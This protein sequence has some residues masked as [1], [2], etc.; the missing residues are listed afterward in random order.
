[1]KYNK[2]IIITLFMFLL[3]VSSVS[4]SLTDGLIS[5]WKFDENTGTNA[6]D[7]VGSNHGTITGATWTTGKINYGLSFDGTN[8][9]LSVLDSPSFDNNKSLVYGGWFNQ[10]SNKNVRILS[11]QGANNPMWSIAIVSDKVVCY[12]RD[13][14]GN[15]IA[16][17][18]TS[19]ITDNTWNMAYCVADGTTLKLYF[20]GVNEAN[21][22][23]STLS[24]NV[25]PINN[26]D[27]GR[28]YTGEYFN[29]L[30][31]EVAIWINKS[32]SNEQILQI[33]N[34]GAG[35]QY[36]FTTES[37]KFKITTNL[38]DFNVS[39]TPNI[40]S[41][42]VNI[43]NV[44]IADFEIAGTTTKIIK[45]KVGNYY[46]SDL[47]QVPSTCV[48]YAYDETEGITFK[49]VN[50]SVGNYEIY[51]KNE[52]SNWVYV[53]YFTDVSG[54]FDLPLY[55][56][57]VMPINS[58]STS[59]TTYLDL[60]DETLY[61]IT[62]NATNYE[63]QTYTDYNISLNGS[64]STTLIPLTKVNFLAKDLYNNDV[65]TFNITY[66]GTTYN[67]SQTISIPTGAGYYNFTFSKTNWYNYTQE[68]YLESIEQTKTFTNLYQ[69]VFNVTL[70]DISTNATINEN[71]VFN[72]TY[73]GTTYT[74]NIT[75]GTTSFNTIYGVHSNLFM[76]TDTYYNHYESDV[77]VT[78]ATNNQIYYLYK[79]RS[80]WF[81]LKDF[82]N[83]DSLENFSVSVYSETNVYNGSTTNNVIKLDNFT[84]GVYSV[85]YFKTGY[86]NVNY[87]ITIQNKSHQTLTGYMVNESLDNYASTIFNIENVVTSGSIYGATI[88]MYKLINNEWV[89][90]AS[91]FSDITGR[92]SFGFLTQLE[93]KFV[94]TKTGYEQREFLLMPLYTTYTIKMTPTQTPYTQYNTNWA[95]YLS[96]NGIFY[97][98]QLNVFDVSLSSGKGTFE[99]YDITITNYDGTNQ[100]ITCT[101]AYG[102]SDEVNLSVLANSYSDVIKITLDVKESG[103]TT[104]TFVYSYAI[105]DFYLNNTL[106]S[107][108]DIT[109]TAG[110][111]GL[112]KGMLY[113]LITIIMVGVIAFVS[114][115]V[116]IPVMITSGL[117]FALIT[118][119]FAY[120]DF[121]SFYIAHLIGL[122]VLLIIFFSRGATN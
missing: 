58:D 8:D 80:V 104:K 105:S 89:L 36:P 17:T 96:N 18:S 68:F 22:S 45:D 86:T 32:L 98:N 77:N 81:Y 28:L 5:Y 34:A 26:L 84:T 25:N 16:P 37:E 67:N 56:K 42:Y 33:Y 76:T 61:N 113:T 70:K 107:W 43:E 27:I 88:S 66:S 29:G 92:A 119:T 46:M 57:I 10:T 74:Y 60:T 20:N 2:I 75:N 106:Y 114:V 83:G 9:Y 1:M 21:A 38:N 24:N 90:V 99:N 97:N 71:G 87:F 47:E 63:S 14:S 103:L 91:R 95:Y 118:Y 3:L 112:E 94:I 59:L 31:D 6:S 73:S 69:N 40:Y 85:T 30:I 100:T 115:S 120:I 101:N 102:C 62:I 64:I 116:G 111:G 55:Y 39:I 11:N 79:D 15:I 121:I 93:Y 109:S 78:T 54:G 117:T 4:A 19:T 48:D 51:C 49:W 72:F 13:A 7:S 110:I 23:M 44:S 108:K 50:E 65:D 122:G 12:L 53:T 82:V 35:L 52:S 41:D